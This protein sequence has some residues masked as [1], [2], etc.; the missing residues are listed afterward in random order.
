MQNAFTDFILKFNRKYKNHEDFI[1]R[2]KIFESNLA[3]IQEMNIKSHGVCKM[4]LNKFAD[5]TDEE[6]HKYGGF[7]LDVEEKSKFE[8]RNLA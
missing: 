3:K 4:G 6:F 8:S 1:K 7:V 5:L 2:Q